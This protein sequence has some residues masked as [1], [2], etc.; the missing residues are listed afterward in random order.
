M[1]CRPKKTNLLWAIHLTGVNCQKINAKSR[2]MNVKL[3]DTL[4]GVAMEVQ[5]RRVATS[6]SFVALFTNHLC[7]IAKR[8]NRT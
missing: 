3:T 5:R 8:L 7:N 6:Q 4:R 2:H 1:T